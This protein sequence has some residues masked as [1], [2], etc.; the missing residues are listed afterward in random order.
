MRTKSYDITWIQTQLTLIRWYLDAATRAS[1]EAVRQKIQQAR[2]VY[3]AAAR[4]LSQM[5]LSEDQRESI[6]R[7]MS[8][9]RCRLDAAQDGI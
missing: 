3:E 4:A 8:V 1:A 2:E 5:D 9:L 6:D 7:E